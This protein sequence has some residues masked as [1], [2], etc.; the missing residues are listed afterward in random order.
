M[1]RR[2]TSWP[3]ESVPPPTSTAPPR[4]SFPKGLLIPW[5]AA[6]RDR[7]A[8]DAV[9]RALA[10]IEDPGTAVVVC[11]QQPGIWGGPLYSLYKAAT[12]VAW[13]DRLTAAGAPAVAVF[14]M[15]ADDADWDEIAWGT[16]PRSDLGLLRERWTSPRPTA[17]HWVGSAGLAPAVPEEAAGGPPPSG[18]RAAL[19]RGT[20]AETFAAFLESLLGDRGLLVLDA[21]WPEVREAGRPLWERYIDDHEAIA[22]AVGEQGRAAFGAGEEPPIRGEEAARGLFPLDGERR[23]D[24]DP[25]EWQGEVRRRL[26]A[27]GG[28]SLAP[29]VVL[30]APLQD[31]LLGPQAQIVGRGEAAYL[32]QLHPVYRRLEIREPVRIERLHATLV[33]AGVLPRERLRDAVEDPEAYVAERAQDAVPAGLRAALPDL[34]KTIRTRLEDLT[35]SA[36]T[37]ATDLGQL[38]ASAARKIDQQMNRLAD[39]VDRKARQ[40]LYAEEPRLRHVPEFLRPRRG[41]QDRGLSAI[42]APL[43]LGEAAGETVLAAAAAHL[44][45]LHDGVR[46]H[47]AIEVNDA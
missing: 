25:G 16:V 44:D 21:R 14:W 10:R 4:P 17:R 45:R 18:V 5:H 30:R 1:R 26:A 29:S 43:L 39:A 40:S 24:L 8:P 33:P 37:W 9:L 15:G 20:V 3:E 7:N 22:E 28:R 42:T 13:A 27:D 23:E 6:L 2:L 11:G 32:R 35:G 38:G 36:A 41:P 46:H 34:R 19:A 12:A 47:V 31:F